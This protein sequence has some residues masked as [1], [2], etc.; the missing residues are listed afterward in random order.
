MTLVNEVW[1]DNEIGN[2]KIWKRM[3]FN[4]EWVLESNDLGID[5]VKCKFCHEARM[6]ISTIEERHCQR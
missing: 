5:I 2:I 3:G 1:Y 4:H 6:W